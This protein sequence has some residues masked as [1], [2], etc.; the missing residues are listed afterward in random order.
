M[1]LLTLFYDSGVD[2]TLME[3][4]AALDIPGYTKI[5][6]VIGV[7]GRGPKLNTPVF[8][9]FDNI[10]Y[11]ILPTEDV[12]RVTRAIR[13]LQTSFRLKPGITMFTQDIDVIP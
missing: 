8:P 7:G 4:L 1:K 3:V 13:R 10:L 2:Q 6:D 9:G 11:I 12:G 5:Q